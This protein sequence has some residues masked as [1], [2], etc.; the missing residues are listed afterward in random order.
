MLIGIYFHELHSLNTV[1]QVYTPYKHYH[2]VPLIICLFCIQVFYWMKGFY[3]LDFFNCNRKHFLLIL[4]QQDH[5]AVYCKY[6]PQRALVTVLSTCSANELHNEWAQYGA[7]LSVAATLPIADCRL[8]WSGWVLFGPVWPGLLLQVLK[9][10]LKRRKI[11][12]CIWL[13][14]V[15]ACSKNTEILL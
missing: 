12:P 2:V 3:Q 6:F 8:V 11:L 1:W 14:A 9:T 7:M 4:I 5:L 13:T 10:E 15:E